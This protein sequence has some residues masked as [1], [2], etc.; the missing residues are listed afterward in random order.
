MFNTIDWNDIKYGLLYNSYFLNSL[1]NLAI[2]PERF[3]KILLTRKTSSNG[4]YQVQFYIH[5]KP[6][7][8]IVDEYFPAHESKQWVFS[9]SGP[10]EFWVQLMEKAWA[11]VCGNY[12]A[13]NGGV[14]SDAISCLIESPCYTLNVERLG[15]D[16][17]WNEIVEAITNKYVICSN[18]ISDQD[19]LLRSLGLES[20]QP[21]S[22][23][24][25]KEYMGLRFVRLRNP[26]AGY[27]WKG[28]YSD[29][30]EKWTSELKNFLGYINDIDGVFFMLFDDFCKYFHFTYV[31]KFHLGFNYNFKKFRQDKKDNFVCS[32]IIVQNKQRVYIGLHQKQERFYKKVIDYKPLPARLLVAKYD[33]SA[34]EGENCYE[35]IG[36][37]YSHHDKLYV[38]A[39]LSEGEYH[40]FSNVKWIYD[41]P[42]KIIISTYSADSIEVLHQDR[43]D[44]PIDYLSQI[45]TSYLNKNTRADNCYE[46]ISESK[47]LE[48]NHIGYAMINYTNN[49]DNGNFLIS[50]VNHSSECSII[51]GTCSKIDGINQIFLQK[52]S[53]KT[54]IFETNV[55]HL[56]PFIVEETT[57]DSYC[58]DNDNDTPNPIRGFIGRNIEAFEKKKLANDVYIMQ[59]STRGKIYFVIVNENE[60][61]YYKVKLNFN[62]LVNLTVPLNEKIVRCRNFEYFE[63]IKTSSNDMPDYEFTISMKSLS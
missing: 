12:A 15:K 60:K 55:D 43:L 11:K 29:S 53:N 59:Y 61:L 35:F 21:Y 45:L 24:D 50:F 8:V 26:W 56:K 20:N 63:L 33:S 31:S 25:A 1:S 4:L 41:E 34:Q 27:E 51:S 2:V 49:H 30:S 9:Y 7:I 36:S 58:L 48:D 46:F 40:I 23:I 52:R 16:R 19:V 57:I 44:I 18:S 6:K 13:T 42:C 3:N 39:I 22:I 37:D 10:N 62:K 47:S 5:G 38:S 32:K 14:P 28:E 54:V 17:I